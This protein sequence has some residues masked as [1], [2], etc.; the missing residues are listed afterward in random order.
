MLSKA[1]PRLSEID[2][3]VAFCLPAAGRKTQLSHL[4]FNQPGACLLEHPLYVFQDNFFNFR[5]GIIRLQARRGEEKQR[6][7]RSNTSLSGNAM[8]PTQE[9]GCTYVILQGLAKKRPPGMVNFVPAVA[10]HF[11]L[12][13]PDKFSHPPWGPLFSPALQNNLR[14]PL[15]LGRHHCVP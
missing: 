14:T 7:C 13:L 5:N 3:K 8:V 6:Y 10:C 2:V 15:F 12:N 9:K 11:C 4:I 1:D